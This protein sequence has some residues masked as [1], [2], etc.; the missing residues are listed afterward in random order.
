MFYRQLP[1][2]TSLETLQ[3]RNTQRTLS[4]FPLGVDTLFNLQGN[5]YLLDVDSITLW[6]FSNTFIVK[7]KWW[8]TIP[9]ISTK[10]TNTFNNFKSLNIEKPWNMML[11]IQVLVWYR[12]KNVVW[13]NR[14]MGSQSSSIE[15]W[16]SKGNTV[17][18]MYSTQ[19]PIS[20]ETFHHTCISVKTFI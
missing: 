9:S 12:R 14:L 10:Q 3:M 18:C 2:L 7:R 15:N 11:E 13:I 6:M 19:I 5:N 1:A 16:I 8:S 4:N 17:M 20:K